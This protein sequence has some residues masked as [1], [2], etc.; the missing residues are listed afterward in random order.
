MT[1]IEL[2]SDIVLFLR[3]LIFITSIILCIIGIVYA[4]NII[5]DCMYK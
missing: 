4:I 5:M 2:M 1:V 3:I